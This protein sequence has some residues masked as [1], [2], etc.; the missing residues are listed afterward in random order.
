MAVGPDLLRRMDTPGPRYTSYPTADRFHEAFS[1]SSWRSALA[2]R[3]GKA[4]PLSLYVHLPF[5]ASLCY[6]CACNKVVTKRHERAA[7]YLQALKQELDLVCAAMGSRQGVAQLHLGG[8]TPTFLSD[9]ELSALVSW[10]EQAFDI[11]A[12][13]ERAIEVDP[14]TVDAQRLRA[15]RQ[16]GFNR[17]SFGVQDLDPA[18]QR[19]VHRE[20]SL[21]QVSSLMQLARELGFESTNVDL[22]YGL[23][24]Q[25]PQTMA[26]T[27]AQVLQ[28]QPDRVALYGYAH[29]PQ[30][31]VAQ[32]RIDSAALP[33]AGERLMMLS[34]ALQ[35]FADAGYHYIGMDHFARPQDSLARAREAGTLKRNFQ[36]Y[37]VH[38]CDDLLALGVSAISQVAGHYAQN[39]KTIEDYEA[40]LAGG[41]LPTQR[42]YACTVEDLLRREVVM[43]IMCQG[44][45]DVPHIEQRHGITFT[46]HFADVLPALER[47]ARDGMLRELAQG[48]ELT[49]LGW[50]FVRAVAMAFDE[51]LQAAQ[52]PGARFSRVI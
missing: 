6:Y 33:G 15:L 8:G 21:A 10:L 50:Y 4:S 45:I 18:V 9:E 2:T 32:R 19:A 26:H 34:V 13:A 11:H 43:A 12:D 1:V 44:R 24:L 52:G 48:W 36:G 5:C 38:A 49:P 17:L 3:A 20:Q 51:H 31:F 22:I 41:E 29:L 16:M 25:T 28:L 30:R 47:F 42:G 39:A 35:A 37:S 23:P 27:V 14:R 7:P 46:E 40:A